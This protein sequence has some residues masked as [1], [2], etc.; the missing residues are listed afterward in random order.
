M[1]RPVLRGSKGE[2]IRSLRGGEK[3]ADELAAAL[4]VTPNAIR[5]HLAELE[6][7][8]LVGQR[9]VR[10]GP[11]KPSHGYSLS[12][13]GE[14][15]FPKQYDAVLNAVLEDVREGSGTREIEAL[16]ARLGRR[17][18]ADHERRFAGLSPEQR[19]SEALALLGEMGGAATVTVDPAG[20]A[21]FT[22]AGT[23]CPLASVVGQHPECCG[24]LQSFLA[25]V[26][27][28]TEVEETCEKDTALGPPRCRFQVTPPTAR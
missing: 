18:A 20:G 7:D 23:S 14:A 2:I 15:L 3:T 21:A 26:L 19:V 4:S 10:R 22:I 25:E 17:L 12:P 11:R 8:G 27:P 1:E 5:F 16:F 24:L 9:S 13:A 28:G 6:R